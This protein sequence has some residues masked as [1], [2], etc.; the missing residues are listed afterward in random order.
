[1]ARATEPRD[2]PSDCFID[3]KSLADNLEH[4]TGTGNAFDT[5]EI[6]VYHAEIAMICAALRAYRDRDTLIGIIHKAAK[7]W[8][9]MEHSRET[10][11]FPEMI[12]DRIIGWPK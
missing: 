4:I 5:T 9:E 1:M 7:D 12:A 6:Y 3:P 10:P 2:Q 11:E 8:H